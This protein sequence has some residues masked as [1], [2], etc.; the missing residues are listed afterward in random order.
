MTIG[1]K[2]SLLEAGLK[3]RAAAA[4][5][6]EEGAMAGFH[7]AAPPPH[8]SADVSIAWPIAG[9]KLLRKPPLKIAEELKAVFAADFDAQSAAPGFVNLK[10]KD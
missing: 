9:A 10:F 3:S 4:F 8:I 7:L 5:A 1:L 2:L 6:L